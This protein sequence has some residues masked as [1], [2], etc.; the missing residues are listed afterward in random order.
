[1][2]D[3]CLTTDSVTLKDSTDLVMQQIDM[4]FDTSPREVLGEPYYGSDFEKFLWDMTASET[5][6]NNYITNL[7]NS[8]VDLMGHQINVVSQIF[9]G[10]QHD[11]IMVDISIIAPDGSQYD[12]LYSIQ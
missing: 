8:N 11:I 7:I 10:T 2:I 3:F 1:M 12:K 4:L 6:I 9:M 5:T